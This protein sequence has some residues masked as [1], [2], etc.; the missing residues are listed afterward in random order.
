V[1]LGLKHRLKFIKFLWKTY[2][3]VVIGPIVN[4]RD[5]VVAARLTDP[6]FAGS[7]S[8]YHQILPS[9]DL[10]RPTILP[11]LDLFRPTR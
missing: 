10:F 2:L 6:A 7:L 8:P 4:A 1:T 3:T 11:S 5:Q 9:L